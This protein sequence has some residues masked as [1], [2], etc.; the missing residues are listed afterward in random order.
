M[1]HKKCSQLLE[2]RENLSFWL[3]RCFED[4]HR[5][6]HYTRIARINIAVL[7]IAVPVSRE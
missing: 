4:G 3:Q 5:D 1:F 7:R 6:R 2:N